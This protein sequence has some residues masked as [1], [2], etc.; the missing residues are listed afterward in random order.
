[1]AAT[2]SG[3]VV[4]EN[5][6][7]VPGGGSCLSFTGQMWFAPGQTLRGVYRYFNT[8]NESFEFVSR[9]FA[10]VHVRLFSLSLFYDLSL[11]SGGEIRSL[12]YSGN[13]ADCQGCL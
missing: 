8:Y 10:E 1:M 4:L 9:H 6:T 11:L 2:V 3:I 5:P 7:P 12:S 13:R